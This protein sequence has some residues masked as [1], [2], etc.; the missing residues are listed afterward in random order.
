MSKR[1][2]LSS[3]GQI[4]I[5]K[6]FRGS[7]KLKPGTQL[8]V[9]VEEGRLILEPLKSFADALCGLGKEIREDMDAKE[10]IDKERESWKE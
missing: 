2:R 5:P 8:K 3:K 6:E 4:V 1:V 10:Y 9:E 7:L